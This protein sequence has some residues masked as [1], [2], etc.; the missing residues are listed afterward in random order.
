[1]T[2]FQRFSLGLTGLLIACLAGCS[3]GEG[4]FQGYAEGEFVLVAS[5]YG[6]TLETL[7]VSRGQE[8]TAGAP[9][10]TLE[11]A[12]EAAAVREAEARMENLRQARRPPEQSA[13]RAQVEAGKAA[14]KLSTLQLAQQEK[15]AR[16]GFISETRLA[17]ARALR[18]RDAA[19]LANSEAQWA[20]SRESL[21]RDPEVAAADAVLAQA[22]TRLAQKAPASPAAA[23]VQDTF[24]NVGEWVPPTV[25]VVSLLPPG[26]I[27]LRFFVPEAVVATVKPGQSVQV[28]CDGCGAPFSARVTYVSSRAEYTPPVIYGREA[29]AKL[30]YLIEA[31]PAAADALRLSP[32]QPVDVRLESP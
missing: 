19:Q 1:M 24:F 4:G 23:K 18:D 11:H 17:E 22:R 13:V 3:S 12:A 26:N 8:V 5:P 16:A 27:K 14:L 7:A 2:S 20:T 21:G 30:V 10:F 25:P 9:L 32:G 29:R 6:G 28:R 31:R 15:L